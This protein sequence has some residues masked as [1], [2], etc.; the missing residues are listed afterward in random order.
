M[1]KALDVDIGEEEDKKGFFLAITKLSDRVPFQGQRPALGR[2][3]QTTRRKG[4]GKK[5]QF[6]VCVCVPKIES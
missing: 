5:Q 4:R 3:N 6:L 2:V 1:V